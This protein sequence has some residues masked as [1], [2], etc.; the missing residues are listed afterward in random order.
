[1]RMAW[2]LLALVLATAPLRGQTLGG[3]YTVTGV[4]EGAFSGGI[5]NVSIPHPYTPNC[6]LSNVTVFL[7]TPGGIVPLTCG[8]VLACQCWGLA[9]N[10]TITMSGSVVGNGDVPGDLGIAAILHVGHITVYN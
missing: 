7:N 5:F 9:T 3:T 4:V 1:M 6:G 2:V 8:P 10:A